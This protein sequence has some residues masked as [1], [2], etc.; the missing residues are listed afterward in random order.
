VT[1]RAR[2]VS[3]APVSGVSGTGKRII[4]LWA[5]GVPAELTT[6]PEASAGAAE[7]FGTE[8]H[9]T[10]IACMACAD[11]SDEADA[12]MPTDADPVSPATKVTAAVTSRALESL[13]G[14]VFVVL[15]RSP[16]GAWRSALISPFQE[17]IV[18]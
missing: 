11:E 15:G 5:S 13:P 9:P 6:S 14:R 17:A 7:Y 16:K 1:V 10:P 2:G 8:D 3:G 18:A 4:V 12:D